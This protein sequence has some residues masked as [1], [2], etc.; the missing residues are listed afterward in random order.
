MADVRRTDAGNTAAALGLTQQ[1]LS[2]ME[3]GQ[4]PISL[5]QRRLMVNEPGIAPEELGLTTSRSYRPVVLEE[6]DVTASRVRWRSE[7]RWLDRHRWELARL[8]AQLSPA[9]HRVHRT[10]LIAAPAWQLSEPISLR[11]M[12]A[13]LDEGRQTAAATGREPESELVRPLRAPRTRFD[14]YTSAIRHLSPPALFDS[15]TSY[16]LL[17]ASLGLT[18][19]GSAW[20]RTS[21]SS[22]C[23]RRS[24]TNSRRSAWMWGCPAPRRSWWAGCRSGT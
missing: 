14:R 8:A 21:T 18:G 6:H 7:R 12:A 16:R 9:G 23:R 3:K 15:R 1:H 22:T 4:R 19:S 5:E 13:T 17:D 11:S 2:Q 10:S 24:G 20:R